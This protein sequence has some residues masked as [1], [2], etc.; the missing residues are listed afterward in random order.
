VG[1]IAG[2]WAAA[3]MTVAY[4]PFKLRLRYEPGTLRSYASFS[5]PLFVASG[6]SVLMA[7]GALLSAKADLGL[8]AAGVIVLAA[9]ITNFTDRVDELVT[10]TLYP[11]ICAVKDRT[12][13]LYES[14][15]KSN[16]LALM[17]AVPF[18]T[19]LTLFCSDLVDFGIGDR[20]RPA[21][22]VLQVYGLTAAVGHIG[23]NWSAYFRAR[24]ETRPI[25]VSSVAAMLAFFAS[26]IPLLLLFGLR[27]FA[28]GVAVQALVALCVRGYYLQ[29]LFDGFSFLRHAARAFLPTVPAVAI[30]L[31]LRQVEPSDRTFAIAA[32]ELSV[33]V[34][35]TVAATW[36]L[37]SRLLRETFGY[38]AARQAARAG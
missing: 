9:T 20:W 27:G 37:E 15:V 33:Y 8:A 14:F 30:V 34:A 22:T 28:V 6:A 29:R 23:F 5:W 2:S 21:I 36:Y 26:A 31:L 1:V 11:A 19:A 7:Q 16:R 25:A 3:A 10:G 24:G 38:L 17:W 32:G 4:S 13:L 35:I 12:E 18:G